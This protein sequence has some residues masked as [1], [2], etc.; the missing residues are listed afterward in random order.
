VVSF[1]NLE[2][3]ELEGHR[4]EKGVLLLFYVAFT[5]FINFL[6]CFFAVNYVGCRLALSIYLTLY[7][8][9]FEIFLTLVILLMCYLSILSVHY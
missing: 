9:I 5:F 2:N 8:I 6:F 7:R 1:D 4:E 3:E